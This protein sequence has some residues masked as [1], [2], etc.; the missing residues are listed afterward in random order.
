M[1]LV[2]VHGYLLRGT[3]SNI[4]CANVAK[5]WKS[6]GHAVT[7]LCQD[8]KAESL[9]FVDECFIGT[10]NIPSEAPKPGSI[11]VVVPDINGLLLVYVHNRYEGFEVKA[12]GDSQCSLAE[13][14]RHIEMTAAGLRKVLAQ[15]VDRVL[16]NHSLLSPVIAKRACEGGKIPFDVKIHGSSISFSLKERPELVRYA[17]EGLSGCEKIVAGTAY[18]CRLLEETFAQ[19]KQEIGL[20][21]KRVIIP[22]GMDP[23]VFQL[24]DESTEVNQQRFCEKIERFI[25]MKPGGRNATRITPPTTTT[26]SP[27]KELHNSLI[28]LAGTYDQWAADSDLLN[29]WP[30]IAESDPIIVYFGAYLNTK[31]VGEIVASFPAVLREVPSARLLVVGY[32]SYREHI[33]GMLSSLE[34]GDTEAFTAFCQAGDFVDA[35]PDQLRDVFRKLSPEERRRVTVTGIMEHGQL[36]EILSMASVSLVCTKGAEAFGM[37]AVESMASGTL[38]ICNYHS[39]LADILDVMKGEDPELEEVMHMQPQPGRNA[40]E[41]VDGFFMMQDLPGRVLKA[42]HYLYPNG[43]FQDHSRRREV[44]QKLRRIAVEN[45]SWSKICKLLLEPLA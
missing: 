16:A 40:F 36:R 28:A 27:N 29:R 26:A 22:P 42:L 6:F 8:H 44:A 17:V 4:Y 37:V 35:S 19:H 14:D 33:E 11:R 30:K 3:G 21:R 31:G 7:V 34:A 39:G 41:L 13:I 15:G 23:D 24:P 38:P 12:M 45:F 2:I 10:D 5:T 1:H 43:Q 20:L 9:D 18:I 25:S 32:G